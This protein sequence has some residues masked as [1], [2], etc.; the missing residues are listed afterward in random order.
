MFEL[1]KK[2]IRISGTS[3]WLDAQRQVPLSFISHAHS[4]HIKKH[5]KIIAT[6][7]TISFYHQRCHQVDSIALTYGAPYQIENLTIELFPA[8]HI[9]GSAQILVI[10]DD[11]RLVYTGDLNLQRSLTAQPIEIRNADILIIESTF[12][13]PQ[14][15]FPQRSESIE[16]L[17]AFIDKCFLMGQVPVIMSYSLGKSQEII[18]ILGD[19]DYQMSVYHSIYTMTKIYEQHGIALKNYQLYGGE[20]LSNRVM[21]IPPHLKNWAGKNNRGSMRRLIVTGWAVDAAAK[22]RYQADEGVPLSDH[23]D[24]EDLITYVKK[25]SPKKVYTTHGFDEFTFY[26]KK[27]GF[28]ASPLTTSSQISLC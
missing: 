13:T 20:H 7:E 2:G 11:V 9:L 3:L 5:Q 27:E 4:D 6:P 8:G 16:K 10:K 17:V 28:D 12:G 22:Y 18:K 21:I 1:D 25:V 15:K 24:F 26:L 19:L 23:A 14:Y